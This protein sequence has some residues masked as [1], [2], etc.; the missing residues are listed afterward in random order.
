MNGLPPPVDGWYD[1]FNGIRIPSTGICAS[2]EEL[3]SEVI[4][5]KL[6]MGIKVSSQ[7]KEEVS[8]VNRLCQSRRVDCRKTDC[9]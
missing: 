4:R 3:V 7:Q 1:V 2:F 6:S 9:C 5:K 8:L